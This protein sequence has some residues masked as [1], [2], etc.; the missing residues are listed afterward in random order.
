MSSWPSYTWDAST[1]RYRDS[2]G[3]FVPRTAV[4]TALDEAIDQAGL[5]VKADALLLQSGTINLPE[6]Q[7]RTEANLKAI[8]TMSGA[9]A[10]GG[11]AQATAADWAVVGNRLKAEYAHLYHFA[12]EI[13]QGL[14]L[15]GRFLARA[16]MYASA[17]SGTYEAVLRRNDL[18]TN[19][20]LRE[21]RY[22]HSSRSCDPCIVYEDMGWQPPGILPNVGR[23]CDCL[24]NCQCSF[25]R[26][27]AAQGTPAAE[28][29]R[30]RDAL[31]TGRRVGIAAKPGPLPQPFFPPSPVPGVPLAVQAPAHEPAGTPA[32]KFTPSPR[33]QANRD[34]TV[35]IDVA[36]LN[37][38]WERD[39]GFHLGPG[40]S[41]PPGRYEEFGRFAA[42]AAATG[43][44][45]EQS[46]VTLDADGTVSFTN[47]RHRF[48]YLRDLGIKKLPVSVPREQAARLRRLYGG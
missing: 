32:L 30:M 37:A 14:P 7:L 28:V 6:W 21:R 9:L 25:V 36:K 42:N 16:Q 15:D 39:T 11:W 48:A 46:E 12:R 41:S 44:P 13:E 33:A 10:V 35:T 47:G 38:A 27:F 43:A 18:A 20:C 2:R 3:R 26:E 23:A 29:Q 24:S 40:E 17:G 19:L 4:R 31:Q 5:R 34:A 8:H 22:R 45:V 1:R